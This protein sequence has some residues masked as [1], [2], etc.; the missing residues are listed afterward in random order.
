MKQLKE[1]LSKEE[2]LQIMGQ[3][4]VNEKYNTDN[5]WFYYTERK[6]MD[7]NRTSDECSPLIFEDGKLIGWGKDFYKKYRQK[8]W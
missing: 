7:G 4:L 5:I 6:W 8:N 2:V 3:P 1:G